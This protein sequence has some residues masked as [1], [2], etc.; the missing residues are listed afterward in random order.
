MKTMY[1]IATTAG[2]PPLLPPL[3]AQPI[4]Q[5]PVW[6]DGLRPSQVQARFP[7]APPRMRRRRRLPAC[8]SWT[9]AHRSPH[10]FRSPERIARHHEPY[11]QWAKTFDSLMGIQGKAGRRICRSLPGKPGA[12]HAIQAGPSRTGRATAHERQRPGSRF[13]SG[14]FFAGHW[15]YYNGAGPA[16]SRTCRPHPVKPTSLS[17]TT[18]SSGSIPA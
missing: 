18:N 13:Q 2:P 9:T 8:G 3:A 5:G 15:L 10:F 7:P 14:E 17:A 12:V 16:S 6:P 4:A 11:E 1:L